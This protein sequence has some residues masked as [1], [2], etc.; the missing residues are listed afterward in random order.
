LPMQT[1]F[2]PSAGSVPPAFARPLLLAATIAA[3][4]AI[5]ACGGGKQPAQTTQVPAG[6]APPT[7]PAATPTP[8]PAPAPV[9]P[10]ASVPELLKS[11]STA[12]AEQRLVAPAAN[13]AVEFY[14]AVLD[15][16]ANNVQAKQAIVDIF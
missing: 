16:D 7:T 9:V 15:K 8:P 4:L 2:S 13:N 1:R 14:L 12:V 3:A 6:G 10:N 11:A 5:A